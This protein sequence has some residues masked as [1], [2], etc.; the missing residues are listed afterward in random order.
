VWMEKELRARD[1]SGFHGGATTAREC[2]LA[3][4]CEAWLSYGDPGE[5]DCVAASSLELDGNP[6]GG[7]SALNDGGE[8]LISNRLQ[9]SWVGWRARGAGGGVGA[10]F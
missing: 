3:A 10:A 4:S 2:W 9:G 7:R 8:N 5:A 1:S 6:R